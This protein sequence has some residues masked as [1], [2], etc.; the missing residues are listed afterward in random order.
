MR[1]FILLMALSL[2]AAAHG[3]ER[4]PSPDPPGAWRQIGQTAAETTSRCIGS[5]TD[6]V[7]AL[8]T[9]IA[10]FIRARDDFCTTATGEKSTFFRNVKPNKDERRKYRVE[11]VIRHKT[12]ERFFRPTGRFLFKTRPGDLEIQTIELIWQGGDRFSGPE[13]GHIRYFLRQRHGRWLVLA[14]DWLSFPTEDD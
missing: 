4:L 11:N 3:A 12:T 9:R 1:L 13:S 2:S 8:E 14:S 7:C 10:C 6:P 5:T